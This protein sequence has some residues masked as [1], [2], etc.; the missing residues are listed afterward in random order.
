MRPIKKFVHPHDKKN[1][2][3]RRHRCPHRLEETVVSELPEFHLV[4]LSFTDLN[5]PRVPHL[6]QNL[7][8]EPEGVPI[9]PVRSGYAGSRSNL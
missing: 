9:G 1:T 5:H 7:E 2:D 8:S 6:E 4:F 3:A